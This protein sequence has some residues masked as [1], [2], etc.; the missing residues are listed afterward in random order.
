M[1]SNESKDPVDSAITLGTTYFKNGQYQDA[2]KLFIKTLWLL[3]SYS[4]DDIIK[5]R[6]TEGLTSGIIS[7]SPIVHPK[8]IK[9]LDNVAACYDKL[10]ELDKALTIGDKMIRKE[11]FNLKCY[12]RRGKILQKLVRDKDAYKNYK[13]ALHEVKKAHNDHN[14]KV[15]QKLIDVVSH[16]M[17]LV[18]QRLE[19]INPNVSNSFTQAENNPLKR[20]FIDPIKEHRSQKEFTRKRLKLAAAIEPVVDIETVDYIGSL[21]L[22]ILPLILNQLNVKDL[23]H[24]CQ[25]SHTYKR[26]IMINYT[27]WFK[28]YKLNSVTNKLFT[29][30]HDFIKILYSKSRFNQIPSFRSLQLSSKLASDEPRLLQK[31]FMSLQD[32]HCDKLIVSA[33]NCATSNII[34]YIV[35][36][37]QFCSNVKELSLTISLRSDKSYEINLL[38][39]FHHLTNLELIF[40]SA[41]VPIRESANTNHNNIESIKDSW[42]PDLE[43]FRL[44]CDSKKIKT[45]PTRALFLSPDNEYHKLHRLCI[46]GVTFC[47]NTQDF[48][49]LKKFPSL[50]ELWLEN[51]H[52]G[53]LLNLLNLFKTEHVFKDGPLESLVFR[54]NMMYPRI[55]ME[56]IPIQTR[57]KYKR[58]LCHLKKLDLMATSIS[59]SGLH[60]LSASLTPE[61]LKC[62]NIGDCP[63][64]Q[65]QQSQNDYNPN[66]F[67]PFDFF[68]KFDSLEYLMLPLL[69]SL[70][71]SSMHMLALQAVDIQ[72]LKVLDLSLNSQITG[73]SIYEIV[74]KLYEIKNK[75][76]L[77]RLII[78][79]C[80]SISH[81][82]VNSVKAKRLVKRIDCVYEREAWRQF[83]VNSFKYK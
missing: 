83:G 68:P 53:K 34:K 2:K 47:E 71:D 81:I 82:T 48:K 37:D 17:S 70:N 19:R 42:C 7:N 65:M 4:K 23:I 32:Y 64:I 1:A 15:S 11:P 28:D 21:P 63:Y 69:G 36:Q 29:Q 80:N 27:N 16:Q 67:S 78:D 31:L 26:V 74:S 50:K 33:P 35:P 57:Y 46:T 66:T 41:V 58:N 39:K 60:R 72:K 55:D 61:N 43:N 13:L 52:N 20:Q 3:K 79:G 40:D 5:I 76:P 59:G 44:L 6:N 24:L 8:L 62:L 9:L 73:V 45:F 30:F 51:N 77:E 10:G 18:K 56:P 49:W 54:E 12:I 14:V 22:E 25:V 75:E 38:N